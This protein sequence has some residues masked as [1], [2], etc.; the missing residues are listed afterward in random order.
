MEKLIESLITKIYYFY[1]RKTYEAVL[2]HSPSLLKYSTE[3]LIKFGGFE[4]SYDW[5]G[6]SQ[7]NER[8]CLGSS[9]IYEHTIY[10][11]HWFASVLV[12]EKNLPLDYTLPKLIETIAHEVAHCLVFDFYPQISE[13]HEIRH[14]TITQQLVETLRSDVLITKLQTEVEELTK[15]K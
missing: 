1:R 11:N 5:Y 6:F 3:P 12:G 10:L 9:K 2:I 7:H 4:L 15:R 8:T 13:E 14:A